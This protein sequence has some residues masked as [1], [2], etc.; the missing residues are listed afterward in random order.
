M[1]GALHRLG[2]GRGEGRAHGGAGFGQGRPGGANGGAREGAEMLWASRWVLVQRYGSEMARS[3]E[4]VAR[5]GQGALATLI[6]AYGALFLF[7]MSR[8]G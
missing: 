2:Q 5:E 8:A 4:A 6:A 3:Q 1:P 7:V